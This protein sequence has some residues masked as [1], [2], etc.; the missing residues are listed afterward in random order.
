M[1]TAR[2]SPGDTL[3]A[4][5]RQ[6]TVMFCDLVGSTA[7]SSD[8]DPEDF[9]DLMRSYLQT[10]SRVVNERGGFVAKYLGDGV[11][12]LFGYPRALEGDTERAVFAALEIK[13]AVTSHLDHHGQPLQVGIGVAT[14]LV[15][16]GDLSADDVDEPD[17]V[18]GAI[19]NLA[20][21][22][23]EISKP[24]QVVVSETTH[25]LTTGAVE[26]EHIG[27][28]DLRGFDKQLGAFAAL[29]RS[30]S[31]TRFDAATHVHGVAPMVGRE[32]EL[33][34]ILGLW[35]RAEAGEGTA[36]LVTGDPGIGKSRLVRAVRDSIS[37][38]HEV[39]RFQCSPV[40]TSAPL[41]PVIE[42]IERAA[43]LD[44]GDSPTRKLHKV[45]AV[46]RLGT[47]D[48]DE[49]TWLI[50]SLLAIPNEQ[51]ALLEV[52]PQKQKEMTLNALVEYV[53]GLARRRPVLVVVED[54]QWIDASTHELLDLLIRSTPQSSVLVVITCRPEY[55][56]TFTE[57]ERVARLQL[58]R[59]SPAE[60]AS[61]ASTSASGHQLPQPVVR[62]IVDRADGVPLFVEELTK[63]VVAMTP[64]DLSTSLQ[65][66]HTQPIPTSLHESLLA[67]LDSF[68]I[69]RD[70]ARVGSVI[71]RRFSFELLAS[72]AA[73][74]SSEIEAALAKLADAE[75]LF[76]EGEPPNSVYTFKHALIQDTAY[77]SLLKARRR[78]LHAAT[79]EA[80]LGEAPDALERE[81]EILAR[82]YT[83][84][85]MNADASQAWLVAG[86][87][88]LSKS[89]LQEASERFTN[90]LAMTVALPDDKA[91]KQLELSLRLGLGV[92]VMALKG[93][94][95]PEVTDAL[96]PARDLAIEL[97][98]LDQLLPVLWGLWL[99]STVRGELATAMT[100][101][102]DMQQWA[103]TE[104]SSTDLLVVAQAAAALTHFW[105]GD[106]QTARTLGHEVERLYSVG[107]HGHVVG[108]TNHDPLTVTLSWATHWLWML[109]LPDEALEAEQRQ[110]G[111]ARE[112]GH[113]FNLCFGLTV[114]AMAHGYRR[115]PEPLIEHT[116]EAMALGK[117]QSIPVA[118]YILGPVFQVSA[119]L[120]LGEYERALQ[121]TLGIRSAW[122]AIGGRLMIPLLTWL[123]AQARIGLGDAAEVV[124][125]IETT[126]HHIEETQERW[127]T[128]ELHRLAGEAHLL[129]GDEELAETNLLRALDSSRSAQAR[130]WE[131]RAATSMARFLTDR[132]QPSE[133]RDLLESTLKWFSE[134][135]ATGDLS[136]ARAELAA[137]S[138][139]D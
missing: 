109:G 68:P 52:T 88:A 41:H 117:A 36:A 85:G 8:L 113:P 46:L 42:R 63:A 47:D 114:G 13:Q 91:R 29:H 120:E 102:Q 3:D 53:V 84:A 15:V 99:S 100:W 107:L 78:E 60:C 124:A 93:W 30:Q 23:S 70:V 122:E 96:V 51:G 110:L 127:I 1:E 77:S 4:E 55:S 40:A 6:L 126:M 61:I 64:G 32:S 101:V 56:H 115:E 76:V 130:G 108:L 57:P 92:A 59:L 138:G 21:R 136:D 79:V 72:I 26:Y 121:M 58:D 73:I 133:A 14:G 62:Q 98:D 24:G 106:Y 129:I 131:L 49:A 94:P 10:C 66:A 54:G 80:L 105:L 123:E 5:R 18:Y 19:P 82:H 37:I 38:Q 69:A 86:H 35:Q 33:D 34:M 89:A 134:G 16:A 97:E 28:H 132:G 74:P 135:L 22:L 50:A 87:Q 119:W 65:G 90:G 137:L 45:Q 111:V 104:S 2:H 125:I 39:L 17:S 9:R 44:P 95:A 12:A 112:L 43:H 31:E 25:E 11:L 139:T 48:T 75:L 7:L 67:R 116:S 20:A 118:E 83:A 81:P 128:P 27:N 103:R 71:G